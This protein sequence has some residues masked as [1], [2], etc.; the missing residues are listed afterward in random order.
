[1]DRAL[2][3]SGSGYEML[4]VFLAVMWLVILERVMS[5][6]PEIFSWNTVNPTA[7]PEM[8]KR[9]TSL[10]HDE[11]DSDRLY[12]RIC[13]RLCGVVNNFCSYISQASRTD[14]RLFRSLAHSL[15]IHRA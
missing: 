8:T 4:E 5:K 3:T 12:R 1:M 7:V 10:T 2:P 13:P 6:F 14:L 11:I 15:Q 9:A